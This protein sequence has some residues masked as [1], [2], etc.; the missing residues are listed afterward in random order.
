MVGLRSRFQQPLV[1]FV[2]TDRTNFRDT[3]AFPKT[4]NAP[5]SY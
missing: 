4:A 1:M 2:L 3:I 5:V